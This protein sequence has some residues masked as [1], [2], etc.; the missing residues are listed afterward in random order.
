[1]RNDYVT[2]RFG[3]YL[4]KRREA[5]KLSQSALGNLVGVHSSVIW[6]WENQARFPT[7]G[8]FALVATAFGEDANDFLASLK[9]GIEDG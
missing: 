2:D 1:M 3:D 7:L 6:K 4:R 5:A 9:S 8:S